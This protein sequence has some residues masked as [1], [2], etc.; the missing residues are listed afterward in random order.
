MKIRYTQ[1]PDELNLG[2]IP[3]KRDEWSEEVSD[4]LV[5][6]AMLPARVQEYGFE[7]QPAK[8]IKKAAADQAAIEQDK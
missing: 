4:D 5:A 8:S 1:G 3:L 2:D 6:Q 7:T